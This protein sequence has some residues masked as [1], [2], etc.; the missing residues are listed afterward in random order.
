MQPVGRQGRRVKAIRV[1][2]TVCGRAKWVLVTNV[3]GDRVRNCLCR[4]G[5]YHDPRAKT[6]GSRYDA[7]VQRCYR[8]TH[9]SSHRYKGRGIR[10]L[11]SSREVFVRWALETFPSSDFIGMDFDRIDNAGHYEPNNLRLA[12]RSENLLNRE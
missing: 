10:V 7:M 2:C 11:F 12:T 8:G 3:R 1:R 6:L 4:R 9:V 5:K